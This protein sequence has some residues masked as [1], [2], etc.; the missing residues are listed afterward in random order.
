VE[1]FEKFL[2]EHKDSEEGAQQQSRRQ[3]WSPPQD[4]KSD[5]SV[6]ETDE[7]P[8]RCGGDVEIGGTSI[9]LRD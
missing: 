9:R 2:N 8:T 6:R 7:S 3:S 4:S 5:I 1:E